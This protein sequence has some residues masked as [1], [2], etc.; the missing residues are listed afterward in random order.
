MK[1]FL[2][3]NN[4]LI[5]V[6]VLVIM[7]SII[8]MYDCKEEEQQNKKRK[9]HKG[10]YCFCDSLSTHCE[11]VLVQFISRHKFYAHFSCL[12]T[13]VSLK[14]IRIINFSNVCVADYRAICRYTRVQRGSE[15]HIC[16]LC[17]YMTLYLPPSC[18]CVCFH[19]LH[20]DQQQL[21]PRTQQNYCVH[22][23]VFVDCAYIECSCDGH[24]INVY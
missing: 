24:T 16:H 20:I 9:L 8:L 21:P 7:E 10:R 1:L 19:L 14:L 18:C 4:V 3:E 5:S 13:Y 15:C 11:V 17:R 2:F 23:S 12:Q 6:S 22:F